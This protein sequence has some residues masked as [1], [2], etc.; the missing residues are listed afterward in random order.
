VNEIAFPKFLSPG[1]VHLSCFFT[2]QY[3]QSWL[4][5]RTSSVLTLRITAVSNFHK[6]RAMEQFNCVC[7]VAEIDFTESCHVIFNRLKKSLLRMSVLYYYAKV[8][9]E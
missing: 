1:N 2:Q 7:K 8:I 4:K 3:Q 5:R 9:L 6:N